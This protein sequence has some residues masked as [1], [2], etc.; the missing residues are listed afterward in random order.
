M[1][2]HLLGKK[3][4]NVYNADNVARVRRD[5]AAAKAAEEAEEQRMQEVD[6]QRR[7]AI[8]RGEVPPPLNEADDEPVKQEARSR[9]PASSG[10]GSLQRKRKR[11]GEDDTDFELR[12]AKERNAN[13]HQIS[14]PAQNSS[15]CTT[16]VD[17][18]G[19]IS[20]FGDEK[21]RAHAQK[22]EE[23]EEETRK[24]RREYEDQYTMRLSNAAGKDGI[25]Q[26]WYSHADAQDEPLKDIWG[27]DDPKR[28]QRDTVRLAANDPLAMMKKGS[29]RRC[30]EKTK[31]GRS[32][33]SGGGGGITMIIIVIIIIILGKEVMGTAS[34]NKKGMDEGNF[35]HAAARESLNGGM[36]RS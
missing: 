2:L 36:N 5:E 7:L 33:S 14:A 4:W 24:K 18:R 35:H 29:S 6:A 17:S 22:N 12:L 8:L 27:N 28:K 1:P 23:A 11:H 13:T 20:L 15:S 16:I 30:G 32:T 25:K 26:P 10:P 34:G 3:S 9:K 21:T 19:H 31:E